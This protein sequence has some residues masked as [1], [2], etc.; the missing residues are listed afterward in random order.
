MV[1]MDVG[2]VLPQV[3][4]LG[5]LLGFAEVNPESREGR[6]KIAPALLNPWKKVEPASGRRDD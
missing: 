3:A 6:P 5:K 4:T 1:E 2:Q